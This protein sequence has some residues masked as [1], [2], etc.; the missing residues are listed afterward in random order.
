MCTIQKTCRL[1]KDVSL[2]VQ[3]T[4]C[5]VDTCGKGVL[6]NSCLQDLRVH[7]GYG[8]P[9]LKT[10]THQGFVACAKLS[11]QRSKPSSILASEVL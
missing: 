9:L 7:A 2:P 11:T 8:E 3:L 1:Q 5:G 10:C 6:V 4:G